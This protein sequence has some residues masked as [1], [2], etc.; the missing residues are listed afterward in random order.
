MNDKRTYQLSYIYEAPPLVPPIITSIKVLYIVTKSWW[1]QWAEFSGFN[2]S[3]GKGLE[4]NQIS[5]SSINLE[6]PDPDQ[7]IF[8][9]KVTWKRLRNW[10]NYDTKRIAFVR[11][12]QPNYDFIKV[13]IL[14]GSERS[15]EVKVPLWY[16]LAEFK[17]RVTKKMKYYSYKCKFVLIY[18]GGKRSLLEEDTK[19]LNE[20]EFYNEVEVEVRSKPNNKAVSFSGVGNYNEED[21]LKRAIEDSMKQTQGK[22]IDYDKVQEVKLKL[23][24][25][26]G[27][28]KY[29]IFVQ[30]LKVLIENVDRILNEKIKALE[31]KNFDRVDGSDVRI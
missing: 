16:T 21:D 5:N 14:V 15:R 24:Q 29:R 27:E 23:A 7:Y 3:S 30:H 18:P 25:V 28:K 4:P 9:P 13:F 20:L 11:N 12:G 17:A 2:G 6:T 19:T 8:L 26:P 31:K 22:S 1:I 10:Y